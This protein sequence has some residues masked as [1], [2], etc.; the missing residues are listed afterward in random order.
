MERLAALREQTGSGFLVDLQ[1][2]PATLLLY[3]L[4]MGA[5]E[6]N[7]LHF[8][9]KLFGTTIHRENRED[10]VAV[11]ILP[12]FCI[13][14]RSGSNWNF[15][16]GME[17]AYAPLSDWLHR[18]L[19]ETLKSLMPNDS[20]YTQTF[21]K[22]EVLMALGYAHHATGSYWIP[23]GAF[24]YRRDNYNRILKEIEESISKDGD[25]S[26]YVCC[27]IFGDSAE[28]CA[29]ALVPFMEFMKE[30]SKRWW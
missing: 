9:G 16:E 22:L 6:A 30:V 4:G 18:L 5:V 8:V 10:I 13:L 21:D 29:Q 24:G 3:A 23:V 20:R 14:G 27:G 28:R 17:R 25:Q 11:Q 1:R 12:P 15:L 2:Y 7:R 19:R 26:L